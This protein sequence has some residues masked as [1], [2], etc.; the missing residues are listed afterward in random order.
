MA[1]RIDTGYYEHFT[2]SYEDFT[3][4]VYLTYAYELFTIW[5]KVQKLQVRT[6]HIQLLFFG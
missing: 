2:C 3:N 6:L 1:L 4:R 5:G